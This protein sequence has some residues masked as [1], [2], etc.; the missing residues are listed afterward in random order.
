M[1]GVIIDT[2]AEWKKFDVP[3]LSNILSSDIVEKI[4]DIT[5]LS[6][7]AVCE[8]AA[9][10][11]AIIDEKRY[12]EDSNETAAHIYGSA[13]ITEGLPE[14]IDVLVARNFRLGLVSASQQKSIEIVLARLSYRDKFDTIVSVNDVPDLRQK[15]H[16]DGYLEALRRL[17]ANPEASMIL[18][19][20]NPG[21]QA[22]KAAGCFVIG[23]RGHL[24]HDYEQ[25]QADSHAGT[26]DEVRQ[27]VEK[28]SIRP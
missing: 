2:E 19:D 26:M 10:L 27:I 8:R 16:P 17:D 15:P 25:M 11:G 14:L 24:M 21:I 6:I 23:F 5:G 13:V 22:A 1:D 20:S 12:T 9:A 4:G 28:S 7:K 3:Y 18:E